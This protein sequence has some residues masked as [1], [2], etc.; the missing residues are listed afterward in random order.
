VEANTLDFSN[1]IQAILPVNPHPRLRVTPAQA[2]QW[3]SLYPNIPLLYFFQME[4]NLT[5]LRLRAGLGGGWEAFATL[6]VITVWGGCEDGL[7]EG[8]HHEFGFFDVGRTSIYKNQV[9]VVVIKY[10]QV[11]YYSDQGEGPKVQDPVL[12]LTRS[13]YESTSAAMAVSLQVKPP[14]TGNSYGATSGW[15]SEFQFT[16]R[17]S[18]NSSIDTYFGAGA[19]HRQS[20]NRLVQP[21]GFRDQL[22]IHAMVEGWRHCAWRPFYQLLYQT[23]TA[24]PLLGTQWN[25]PSLQQDLGVHWLCRRDLVFTLSYLKDI[26]TNNNTMEMALIAEASWRF[27]KGRS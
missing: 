20:G 24:Y 27:G 21:E 19:V 7:I 6:P 23:G 9:R 13:V 12:G 15:D 1:Q 2:Q 10:G 4:T 11:V 14:L 26:T 17:W 5:S 22:G 25:Q 3:A 16:G 8:V 18:P